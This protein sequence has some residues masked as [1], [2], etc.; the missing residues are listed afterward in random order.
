MSTPKVA[1]EVALVEFQRWADAMRLTRKLDPDKMNDADKGSLN[2]V[3]EDILGAIEDGLLVVNGEG[4]F[5]FS[6]PG[7]ETLTFYKPTGA[8]VMAMD[9][10]KAGEPTR[11]L[12]KFL[13]DM[14]RSNAAVFAK[15]EMVDLQVCDSI[16]QLFL[17]K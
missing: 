12:T 9:Q 4:L 2:V 11:K 5:E 13:A 14:T 16:A 8:S 3:K 10:A 7:A 15:L 17:A 1:R 6:P